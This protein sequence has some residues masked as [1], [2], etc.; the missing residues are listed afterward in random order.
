MN[1]THPVQLALCSLRHFLKGPGKR[2]QSRRRH[3]CHPTP[4]ALYSGLR[5][6][7]TTEPDGYTHFFS[8]CLHFNKLK[9]VNDVQILMTLFFFVHTHLGSLRGVQVNSKFTLFTYLINSITMAKRQ[10]QE[11]NPCKTSSRSNQAI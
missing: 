9:M 8:G 11:A 10:Q 5:L 1:A 6:K 7:E 3:R 4:S 2:S